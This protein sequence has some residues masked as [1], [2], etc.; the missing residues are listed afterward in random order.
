MNAEQKGF[1]E[2]RFREDYAML[3]T[4]KT[5]SFSQT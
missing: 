2:G 3:E 5:H 1:D 4:A